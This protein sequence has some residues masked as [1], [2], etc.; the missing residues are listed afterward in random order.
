MV[1][2]YP[3]LSFPPMNLRED[4]FPLGTGIGEGLVETEL[5]D[6][7]KDDHPLLL[8]LASS[9]N[10]K[11]RPPPLS[12]GIF[13]FRLVH[14]EYGRQP[15]Q[16]CVDGLDSPLTCARGYS[17]N[18]LLRRRAEVASLGVNFWGGDRKI[19]WLEQGLGLG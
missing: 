16:G 12:S 8:F 3:P 18:N 6:R 19:T 17:L 1:K 14:A 5:L 11:E 10:P 7:R 2:D 15:K 9:T 4:I 13:P